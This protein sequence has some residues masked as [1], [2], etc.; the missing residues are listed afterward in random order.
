[1]ACSVFITVCGAGVI[2]IAVDAPKQTR[3]IIKVT[4][5]AFFNLHHHKGKKR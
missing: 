1:M 5:A 4:E 3:K 2:K